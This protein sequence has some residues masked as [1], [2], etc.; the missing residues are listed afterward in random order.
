MNT[1]VIRPYGRTELALIYSPHLCPE[2]AFRKLKQWIALA[3]GLSDR[4][5][6][7][8]SSPRSRSYTPAQVSLIVA[9][10]GEP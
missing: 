7:L 10:L 6:A 9:A 1:F 5:M 4:L 8:G 2:A 3:P